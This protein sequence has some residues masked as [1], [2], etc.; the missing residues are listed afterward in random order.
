MPG[1]DE[2]GNGGLD[3]MKTCYHECNKFGRICEWQSAIGYAVVTFDHIAPSDA[4]EIFAK[5]QWYDIR[6]TVLIGRG[7]IDLWR[8]PDIQNALPMTVT[9][10]VSLSVSFLAERICKEKP[11]PIKTVCECRTTA[12]LQISR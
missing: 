3:E 12:V 4:T 7:S 5:L 1:E 8:A 11:R 6:N 10:G 9:R 2:G